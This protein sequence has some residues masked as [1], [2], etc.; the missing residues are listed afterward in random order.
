MA[1]RSRRDP[2]WAPRAAARLGLAAVAA[3]CAWWQP[4]R[5]AQPVRI[6]EAVGDTL[7]AAEAASFGLFADEPGL[8]DVV[9]LPAPW[10]GYLA[11]LRLATA[12][13]P[14]VRERNVTTASLRE[15]R[16]RIDAV[17][18]G[19][20]AAPAGADSLG[21]PPDSLRPPVA[22]SDRVKVWP[23][24]PP[25]PARAPRPAARLDAERGGGGARAAK[26]SRWLLG[27][28]LGYR[29]C[30]TDYRDFFTDQGLF[31]VVVSHRLTPSLAP[32]FAFQVGFGDIQDDFEEL[33]EDG[34]SALYALELG[35]TARTRW[36]ERSWLYAGAGGGYYMRS[37]RWGGELFISSEGYLTS[38]TLAWELRNWGFSLRTGFQA[39]LGARG[40][41]ERAIDVQLRY[42]DYGSAELSPF[43]PDHELYAAGRDRWIALSVSLVTRL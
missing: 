22:A 8:R 29:H 18:G 21:A 2:P 30:L 43:G 1:W 14:V 23:E 10:G 31:E 33:S 9:L 13:G 35:L 41:R 25:P 7:D 28:G 34:R 6:H 4:A 5:A 20:A 12:A 38:G 40:P 26:A 3:L 39:V 15:W 24:A 16:A 27:A 37:L 17:L 11:R 19:A 36:G 42:D 32:W